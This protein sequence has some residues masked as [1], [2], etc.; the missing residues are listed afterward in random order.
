MEGTGKGDQPFPLPLS[1]GEVRVPMSPELL[2]TLEADVQRVLD[3]VAGLQRGLD[4]ELERVSGRVS[5]WLAGWS[6]GPGGRASTRSQHPHLT[7]LTSHPTTTRPCAP[8]MAR[9]TY[10]AS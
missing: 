10:M 3:Q 4:E 7:L 2:H 6:R 9:P 1:P 8:W 5:G